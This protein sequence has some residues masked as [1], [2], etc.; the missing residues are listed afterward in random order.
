VNASLLN[1]TVSLTLSFN[2]QEQD[3]TD[4]PLCVFS[5]FCPPRIDTHAV[6]RNNQYRR[7]EIF[8]GC[9]LGTCSLTY[10]EYYFTFHL[11]PAYSDSDPKQC[12]IVIWLLVSTQARI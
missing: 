12:L 6:Y 5:L 3:Q 8:A 1:A 11:Y 7:Q 9:T 2:P 4:R 10:K